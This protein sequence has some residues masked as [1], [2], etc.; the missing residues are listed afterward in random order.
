[1]K[2][3]HELLIF[4]GLLA[5]T[6]AF[7]LSSI[8][9]LTTDSSGNGSL[10]LDKTLIFTFTLPDASIENKGMYLNFETDYDSGSALSTENLG[11][12]SLVY[13]GNISGLQPY[14]TVALTTGYGGTIPQPVTIVYGSGD[15][16]TLSTG[17]T[18]TIPAGTYIIDFDAFYTNNLNITL[19]TNIQMTDGEY[20]YPLTLTIVPEPE[21]VTLGLAGLALGAA[22]LRR[23]RKRAA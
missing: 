21:T 20:A 13:G 11:G 17:S 2:K 6:S 10:T 19:G 8:G 18:I 23:W 9:N 4:L 1:M 5:Q 3:S 16:P 12:P 22:G 14:L 15:S 7:G